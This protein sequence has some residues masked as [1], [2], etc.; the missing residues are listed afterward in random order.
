M[1]VAEVLTLPKIRIKRIAKS[2]HFLEKQL[3]RNFMTI[4]RTRL[5]GPNNRV[6]P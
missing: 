4:K 6:S 5:K 1:P 3:Q 2:Q